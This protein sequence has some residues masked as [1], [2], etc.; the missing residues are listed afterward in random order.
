MYLHL[1]MT[2]SAIFSGSDRSSSVFSL[3][4]RTCASSSFEGGSEVSKCTTIATSSLSASINPGWTLRFVLASRSLPRR[5]GGA[6]LL[7]G[8]ARFSAGLPVALVRLRSTTRGCRCASTASRSRRARAR[9]GAD[10]RWG[11]QVRKSG[12]CDA[13]RHR[14]GCAASGGARTQR[15]LPLIWNGGR[16]RTNCLLPTGVDGVAARC[17]APGARAA[18]WTPSWPSSAPVR[19]AREPRAGGCLRSLHQ[20]AHSSPAAAALPAPVITSSMTAAAGTLVDQFAHAQGGQDLLVTV[21]DDKV[22][23][24]RFVAGA[25]RCLRAGAALRRCSRSDVRGRAKFTPCCDTT[26]PSEEDVA[27]RARARKLVTVS[28]RRWGRASRAGAFDRWRRTIRAEVLE[29]ELRNGRIRARCVTW[30]QQAK[31]ITSDGLE[32]RLLVPDRFH[33]IHVGCQECERSILNS[34][35]NPSKREWTATLQSCL[36]PAYSVVASHALQATHGVVFAHVSIQGYISNVATS[37]VATG[38]G[39]EG[40]KMGNKGGIGIALKIGVWTCVSWRRICA[41]TSTK[42]KRG[43]RSTMLYRV[44]WPRRWRPGSWMTVSRAATDC[45]QA[46]DAV[47]WSGDLNYRV[48]LSREDADNAL[49]ANDLH[50]LKARDQ[51]DNAETRRRLRGLRRGRARLPA[52]VQV[53]QAV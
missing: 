53:R 48:D 43:T 25:A 34:V 12:P 35:A 14:L 15:T 46:F 23:A 45:A 2:S 19:S 31:E 24:Q 17:H 26:I 30:N 32:S 29:E 28:I 5:R 11:G 44:A 38:L 41:P 20:W 42:L 1:R 33:L 39:V 40:A 16:A 47:V 10:G 6:S 7:S 9:A 50:L 13:S 51:L 49:A 27:A 8:A 4:R 36:G 22:H 37:A 3:R 18:H 21:V 52:N